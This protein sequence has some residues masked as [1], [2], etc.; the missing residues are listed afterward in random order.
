MARCITLQRDDLHT[1]QRVTY[2]DLIQKHHLNVAELLFLENALYKLIDEG[3]NVSEVSGTLLQLLQRWITFCSTHV[4]GT[5][6]ES[7]GEWGEPYKLAFWLAERAFQ[8]SYSKFEEQDV[9]HFLEFLC[10]QVGT[11]TNILDVIGKILDILEII[12]QYGGVFPVTSIPHIIAFVCA[13]ST[14]KS[15]L[16]YAP[17]L[18]NVMESL[19]RLDHIA[20]TSLR[21]LE[22]VPGQSPAPGTGNNFSPRHWQKFRIRGALTFLQKC[23]ALNGTPG[24]LIIRQSSIKLY[25]TSHESRRPSHRVERRQL[26]HGHPRT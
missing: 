11:L 2:Y 24:E 9:S 23:F 26:S 16:K 7:C 1:W 12:P 10:A 21:I 22:S 20:H 4:N 15:T 8:C 6:F 25:P 18:W 5:S 19:L 17:R 13:F 3:K 14:S